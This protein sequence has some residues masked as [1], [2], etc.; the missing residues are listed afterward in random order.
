MLTQELRSASF[1]S[2][3][4]G[5]GTGQYTGED[6]RQCKLF[7]GKPVL[8]NAR[9]VNNLFASCLAFFEGNQGKD[10]CMAH[11][12]AVQCRMTNANIPVKQG[13]VGV[14]GTSTDQEF[15]R[16]RFREWALFGVKK[17]LCFLKL[18]HFCY[19][20]QSKSFPRSFLKF[21]SFSN[22]LWIKN[23][24]LTE[25][26]S[27]TYVIVYG[28][29]PPSQSFCGH[30]WVASQNGF[31]GT[32]DSMMQCARPPFWQKKTCNFGIRGSSSAYPPPPFNPNPSFTRYTH[33]TPPKPKPLS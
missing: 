14:S 11:R 31:H 28:N 8:N 16:K 23:S 12:W 7:K 29:L 4:W 32:L 24:F 2:V 26:G 21:V 30:C 5:S 18:C 3:W 9:M 19:Y 13:C 17:K 22:K 25:W 1:E 27:C 20:V 6:K 10:G 15:R 33:P